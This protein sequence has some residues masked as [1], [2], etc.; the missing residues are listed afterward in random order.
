MRTS[1]YRPQGNSVVERLNRTLGASLRAMLIGQTQLEWDKL[2]PQIM[3][4]IRATPHS[5]TLETPNYMMT[6][7]ELRLPDSVTLQEPCEKPMLHTEFAVD[8]KQRMEEA[9]EKLRSQQFAIRQEEGEEPNLYMKGDLVW[10]K[11]HMKKKGENPKLAPKY[12]GIYEIVEVLPYHTYR[13]RKDGKET[14]QHEGRIK[15]HVE[16]AG[17]ETDGNTL[18]ASTN[19]PEEDFEVTDVQDI[20]EDHAIWKEETQGVKQKHTKSESTS[21]VWVQAKPFVP[22]NTV[23][24][25]KNECQAKTGEYND[26]AFEESNVQEPKPYAETCELEGFGDSDMASSSGSGTVMR[27]IKDEPSEQQQEMPKE[28][29]NQPKS[30]NNKGKHVE[31]T[32]HCPL[33][34]ST[35]LKGA[36]A[37]L[38]DFIVQLNKFA[39]TDVEN[40]NK[41]RKQLIICIG[42]PY[43]NTLRNLQPARDSS[44]KMVSDWTDGIGSTGYGVHLNDCRHR[45]KRRQLR[46]K[47]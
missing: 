2:L 42:K 18:V 22:K 21:Q 24:V 1:P 44:W 20:M 29:N 5:T 46:K 34:R 23:E 10:L 4:G 7:R 47:L 12:V 13:V 39:I 9:G 31:V 38:T 14:V 19:K 32:H 15:L 27:E 17:V 43:G 45:I 41:Y 35:R 26:L 16:H 36:P 25:K 8:I 28:T 11:S 3:R 37:G 30:G 40:R 33:R 6:G